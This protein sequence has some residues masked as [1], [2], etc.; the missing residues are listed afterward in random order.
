MTPVDVAWCR[1]LLR[2]SG[3]ITV[4][5]LPRAIPGLRHPTTLG[6]G[7]GW[8]ET[9]PEGTLHTP[10]FPG[11]TEEQQGVHVECRMRSNSTSVSPS[12]RQENRHSSHPCL[13]PHRI[14]LLGA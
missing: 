4:G 9:R 1:T 5:S 2:M 13:P 7:S 6:V 14:I 3:S 8:M 11:V 12:M 10:S